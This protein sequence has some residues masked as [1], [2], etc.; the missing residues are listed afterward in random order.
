MKFLLLGDACLGLSDVSV[1]AEVWHKVVS[2]WWISFINIQL[3]FKLTL[4]VAKAI[5]RLRDIVILAEVWNEVVLL[6]SS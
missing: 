3:V 4:N 6:E 2:F 1:L 5:L